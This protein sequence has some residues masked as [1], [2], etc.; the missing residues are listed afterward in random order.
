MLS[1]GIIDLA[2]GLAFV[3]GVMAALASVITELISRFLGLRGA[4][5]LG[6]LRELLD[7][8]QV[9]TDLTKV[10]Q[11]YTAWKGIVSGTPTG[12]DP[13]SATGVV[14]GSPIL[15]SQGM[16]GNIT[17]RNLFVQASK[18]GRPDVRNAKT[19]KRASGSDLRSLPAYLSPRSFA[20]AVIDLMVPKPAAQTAPAGQAATA[21]QTAAIGQTT[22]D[23]VRQ[24]LHNIMSQD[25][26]PAAVAPLMTLMTSLNTLV[27][28]AENDITSVRT[29]IENWYNEHMDRVS[30]WYKR[31]VAWFTIIAGAILVILLNVNAIT[32]GRT[33]YTNSVIGS[34]VA[35]AAGNHPPC[36]TA[37][38]TC[39]GQLQT[40]LATVAQAGLPIGWA[41]V[42]AC[43]DAHPACNWWQ[44]RGIINPKGNSAWQIVLVI[45]GFLITIVAL[46]PGAR[47]WFGLLNKIGALRS[48]GPKPATAVSD[49]ANYTIVPLPT[50]STAAAAAI[51]T[52]A[53]STSPLEPERPREP[54]PPAG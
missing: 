36:T 26:V 35:T 37:D 42:S 2:I 11:D 23:A 15:R 20:D 18:P 10:E 41:T 1:S 3:F 34:A 6:G 27:T 54:K 16:V 17:S 33:L 28:T 52:T 46:T 47:F 48:T 13:Q 12:E 19:M 45:I 40:D 7:S 29:A 38:P 44:A 21:G 25:P 30:G 49:S 50:A 39:L 53:S 4:Y 22:L 51:T 8:D 9:G 31:H 43:A 5:L 24:S 14:L 32:I